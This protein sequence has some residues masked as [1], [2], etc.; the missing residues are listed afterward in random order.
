VA[1]AAA[2]SACGALADRL[3]DRSVPAHYNQ[4]ADGAG[5]NGLPATDPRCSEWPG[6]HDDT[7]RGGAAWRTGASRSRR[8]SQGGG[9]RARVGLIRRRGRY[10][11]GNG[12]RVPAHGRLLRK[13]RKRL[14]YP[15]H[16]GTRESG[17]YVRHTIMQY[18]LRAAVIR[19]EVGQVPAQL[20]LGQ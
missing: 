17:V 10:L 3:L 12:R 13:F 5:R 2:K 19:A 8:P 6:G 7:R 14:N 20:R 1:S 9:D 15:R 16:P 18:R 4:A 11:C